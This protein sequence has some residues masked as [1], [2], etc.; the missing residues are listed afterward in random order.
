MLVFYQAVVLLFPLSAL[1]S[2]T[3]PFNIYLEH[4]LCYSIAMIAVSFRFRC[5]LAAVMIPPHIGAHALR[6]SEVCR[7]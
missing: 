1:T 2:L 6:G 7:Y 5:I 4:P 3:P